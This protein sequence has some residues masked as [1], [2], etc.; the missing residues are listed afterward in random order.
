MGIFVWKV[1]YMLDVFHSSIYISHFFV[2]FSCK[3]HML[4]AKE[5]HTT[6]N[7]QSPYIVIAAGQYV[8]F[9]I[10]NSYIVCILWPTFRSCIPHCWAIKIYFYVQKFWYISIKSI[11]FHTKNAN[12]LRYHLCKPNILSKLFSKFLNVQEWKIIYQPLIL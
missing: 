1:K 9:F 7:F 3:Y 4:A 6:T 8:Y 5:R 11:Y 12:R 2:P 10:D